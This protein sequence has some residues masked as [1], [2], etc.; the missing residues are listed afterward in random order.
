MADKEN[1]GQ[2]VEKK[3]DG[4][5]KKLSKEERIAARQ[6]QQQQQIE[7]D[8][9]DYS[10]EFYGVFPLIQSKDRIDRV[11]TNVS[12]LNGDLADT[13]VWIR[14]RLFVSRKTTSRIFC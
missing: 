10:K 2:Q 8:E 3:E 4:G 12:D 13:K 11:L 1:A 14:G 9:E 5:K 7:P 6:N